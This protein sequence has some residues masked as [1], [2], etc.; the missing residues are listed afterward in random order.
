MVQ[1]LGK[2]KEAIIQEVIKPLGLTLKSAW[3]RGS[4]THFVAEVHV[5]ENSEVYW[6]NYKTRQILP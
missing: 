6:V 5:I 3:T 4:R 2:K 1:R